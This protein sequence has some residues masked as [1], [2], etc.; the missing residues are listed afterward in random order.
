MFGTQWIYALVE[1]IAA[2][3]VY[4][5]IGQANPGYFPGKSLCFQANPG[6][7]PGKSLCF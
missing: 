2:I 4:I 3:G 5:Y 6:Y 7:F 1:V